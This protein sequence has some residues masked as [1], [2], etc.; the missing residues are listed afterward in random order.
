ML[1]R[2]ELIGFKSFADRTVFDF[3]AGIT[4]VV[5]PNGSGKSNVVD[6]VKWVLGEQSAKSLRGGEMADVIFNGSTSRRGLGFA[7]VS[8]TFDNSKNLLAMQSAEVRITRRVDRTGAGEYF[9]NGQACRLKDIKDLFLGTGAGAH[10]YSIIEQGRVDAL[11]QASQD[12]RRAIFEEAAGVSRFKFKKAECLRRLDRV[13]QNLARL[14]DILGEVDQQLKSIRQQASKAQKYQ[15]YS[16]RLRELRLQLGLREYYAYQSKLTSVNDALQKLR[17]DI[18]AALHQANQWNDQIQHLEIERNRVD[19]ALRNHERSALETDSRIAATA[20]ARER[21]ITLAEQLE[22]EFRREKVLHANL[23]RQI[24]ENE[25][26]VRQTGDELNSVA[27]E[28]AE[29]DALILSLTIQRDHLLRQVDEYRTRIRSNEHSIGEMLSSATQY[30]TEAVTEA[31]SLERNRRERERRAIE[32][33]QSSQALAELEVELRGLLDIQQNHKACADALRR[34]LADFRADRDSLI[35]ESRQLA[36]SIAQWQ[37]ES[38][39]IAGQIEILEAIESNRDATCSGVREVLCLVNDPDQNHRLARIVLGWLPDLLRVAREDAPFID[40]ALGPVAQ[41]FVVSDVTALDDVLPT[42]ADLSSRVDFVCIDPNAGAIAIPPDNDQR[43]VAA[44][45]LVHCVRDDMISLPRQLLANTW[46]VESLTIARELAHSR[47]NGRFVTRQGEVLHPDGTLTVA[48]DQ[49]E[50]GVL[51]RQSELRELLQLADSLSQQIGNAQSDLLHRKGSKSTLDKQI[52]GLQQEIDIVIEQQD[53]LNSQIDKCRAQQFRLRQSVESGQKELRDLESEIERQHK[54]C[55]DSSRNADQLEIQAAELRSQCAELHTA[56]QE[57]ENACGQLEENLDSFRIDGARGAERLTSIRSQYDRL[58][59]ELERRRTESDQFDMRRAE[60]ET[61]IAGVM[62]S[63]LDAQIQLTML[64]ERREEFRLLIAQA[65]NERESAQSLWSELNEKVK[66]H[67]ADWQRQQDALHAHEIDANDLLHRQETLVSRLAE[68]Y[69]ID[70]VAEFATI[71]PHTLTI[72][73]DPAKEQQ[74]V[75]ELRKKLHRLGGVNLDALEELAQIEQKSGQLVIQFEDLTHARRSL[76]EIIQR[77]NVDSKR[78]FLDTLTSVK[79]HFQDL[80]RLL[81]GGGVA[82][83]VVAN[84]DEPLDSDLDI[85][86]RPPGKELRSISLMSGGERT[87]TAVALLLAIF[88]SKPSPFCLLD[89]VDAALDEAN[90]ARLTTVL[91]E[92]ANTAQFIVVTHAKR[93]MAA[94]DVLYGVTMQ[95]SGISK[96]VAVRFEDWPDE[97]KKAA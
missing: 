23:L 41:S 57:A 58:N 93:T 50:A 28:S 91:R 71:D 38:A 8:L 9:I 77:I 59:S 55:A 68:D 39:A 97:H 49:T 51:S 82:D 14:Q 94:A 35:E 12:D 62:E 16:A 63:Q 47:P 15:E 54:M 40:L 11:L 74:E 2:L 80:F 6:A 79:E 18:S 1:K 43:V 88:R 27:Q 48:A 87:L 4:A 10:A 66:S 72:S 95:E 29:R 25:V 36:K 69:Q 83:I 5:G 73:S 33:T 85:L 60:F 3:S 70:L 56:I 76:E 34:D 67:R 13:G 26:A 53:L 17:T 46:I 44:H 75:E 19:S 30:R 37:A 31:A 32:A 7:E 92:F 90:T 64:E 22:K 84:P 61:R 42:L 89:E 45:E 24:G 78:M 52:A 21:D 20:A 65:T 96:R 86:A 81:F